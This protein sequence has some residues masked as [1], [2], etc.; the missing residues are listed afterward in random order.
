MS[1]VEKKATTQLHANLGVRFRAV[2]HAAAGWRCGRPR[3]RSRRQG[4]ADT[5]AGRHARR[6]EENYFHLTVSYFSRVRRPST[7][8]EALNFSPSVQARLSQ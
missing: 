5:R 3:G 8:Q 2:C 1:H 4:R 7:A 6:S